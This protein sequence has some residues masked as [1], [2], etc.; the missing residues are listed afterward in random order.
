MRKTVTTRARVSARRG[1][2]QPLKDGAQRQQRDRTY[3]TVG[4]SIGEGLWVVT[5][6]GMPPKHEL[7]RALRVEHDNASRLTPAPTQIQQRITCCS[8][9]AL[10]IPP[11]NGVITVQVPGAVTESAL[12]VPIITWSVVSDTGTPTIEPTPPIYFVSWG[13][14]ANSGSN[15][16]SPPTEAGEIPGITSEAL[17]MECDSSDDEGDPALSDDTVVSNAVCVLVADSY[18]KLL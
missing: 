5:W 2:F 10:S 13:S 1:P 8:V 6:D 17:D 11:A 12:L 4:E 15:D 16:T 7:A 9:N 18:C 14:S 3:G